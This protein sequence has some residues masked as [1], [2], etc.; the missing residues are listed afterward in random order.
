MVTREFDLSGFDKV[1]VRQ[2][3]TV[4]IS[5]G[6]TFGVVIRVDDNLVQYLQVVKEDSTLK[7][8]V[9]RDR[10]YVN[11]TLQAEVTTPELSRLTLRE[12]SHATVSGSGGDLTIEASGGS[13]ADLSAFAVESATAVAT[14][15]S[16]LTVNV[17][18]KL[19]ADASGG[20]KIYYLGHPT[21]VTTNSTSGA[22][23]LPR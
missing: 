1:D 4:D 11:A 5:Q 18:G 12:G 22:E 8:G 21:E 2:G 17:S 10:I 6:D 7:I 19:V 14:G 15:G 16:Q 13:G 20:S 3:F 9:D 23:I